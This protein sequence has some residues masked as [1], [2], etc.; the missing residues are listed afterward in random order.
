MLR[1]KNNLSY[2]AF[3]TLLTRFILGP[4]ML[5]F[6]LSK[7]ARYSVTVDRLRGGFV[8]TWLPMKLVTAVAWVIPAWETAIG[9][10]LLLGLW[11]RWGLIAMGALLVVLTFGLVVQGAGDVVAQNLLYVLLLFFA[12]KQSESNPFSLDSLLRSRRGTLAD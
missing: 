12:Y 11:Y 1:L 8:E 6:G 9:A 7:V 2:P 10:L 4:L 3:V 5:Q